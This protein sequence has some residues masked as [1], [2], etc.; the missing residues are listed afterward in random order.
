M[1]S[2]SLSLFFPFSKKI[3]FRLLTSDILK[4]ELPPGASYNPRDVGL[5]ES[6]LAQLHLLDSGIGGYRF[7]PMYPNGNGPRPNQ[8]PPPPPSAPKPYLRP[9]GLLSRR[10]SVLSPVVPYKKAKDLSAFPA[11][12]A[13]SAIPYAM[14]SMLMPIFFTN[15]ASNA[16]M[17]PFQ[18]YRMPYSGSGKG[19]RSQYGYRAAA[20][21]L[22]P[23]FILPKPSKPFQFLT[24]PVSASQLTSLLGGVGANSLTGS[25][26][27]NSGSSSSNGGSSGGI[28]SSAADINGPFGNIFGIR[29]IKGI[30][31]LV[32]YLTGGISG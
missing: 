13:P 7:P 27:N 32:S 8:P 20:S 30:K 16:P 29:S 26:N 6:V 12:M 4:D 23:Q 17:A 28:L 5:D 1:T 31:S 19:F 9:G 2:L 21:E 24:Q 25:G 15:P 14:N 18:N 11:S 10:P 22:K 3:H